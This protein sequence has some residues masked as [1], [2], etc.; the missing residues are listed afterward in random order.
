MELTLILK[1]TILNYHLPQ[2][3]SFLIQYLSI[4]RL[5]DDTFTTNVK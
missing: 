2:Y 4:K 5:Q 1:I 3:F